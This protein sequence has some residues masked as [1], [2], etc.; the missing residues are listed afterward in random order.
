[1]QFHCSKPYRAVLAYCTRIETTGFQTVAQIVRSYVGQPREQYP[2]KSWLLYWKLLVWAPL[3]HFGNA[4]VDILLD[5]F[6]NIAAY[7]NPKHLLA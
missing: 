4:I 5:Y 1:M 3:L 7:V 6:V 2:C